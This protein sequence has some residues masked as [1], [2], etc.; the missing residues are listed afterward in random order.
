MYLRPWQAVFIVVAVTCVLTFAEIPRATWPTTA[1]L[2]LA[3]GASAFALMGTAALLGG[4]LRF[5]ESALGGLDR[6]YLTHKWMAVWALAFASFHLVFQA[7][8]KE[9]D[10]A[11]I[12]SLPRHHTRLVRQLSF[13]ALMVIVLLALNRRIPYG[14]WRLWHKT[15]GPLFLIVVA[16]WLSIRSPIE[17]SSPAGIWLGV[18]A[19]AGVAAAFYKLLLYPF[20]ADHANYRVVNV[21]PGPAG[22]HL[23]LAPVKRPIEFR[24]GQFGFLRIKEEGLREPHPFTIAS[25]AGGEGHVHFV[26]RDLGDY[27]HRLVRNTTPGMYAEIYAPF[28]RFLRPVDAQREVWIAGGVGI[29]PF[30]AWLSD[31][32]G[33]NFD[34][35]TFFYFFTPGRE[36]PKAERVAELASRRGVEL[37]PVST[38]PASPEFIDRFRAIVSEAGAAAVRISF[39]GP[40]GLLR[41]VQARMRENGVPERNL[42]F[43]YF[44]FR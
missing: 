19:A 32:A 6:V 38:G 40:Q 1:A 18:I 29:T 43:E 34:R 14:T 42:H 2:S 16:H 33:R 15:S 10:L 37:V 12:L 41:E 5:V 30:L 11:P 31:E 23:Q 35:V 7:E 3:L 26:I 24:P 9:W 17:L 22:V 36:F 25:G 39:C 4:R 20:F 27:T 21:S 28:G 8:L 44:E 13:V